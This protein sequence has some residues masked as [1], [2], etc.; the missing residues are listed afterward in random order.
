MTTLKPLL[1]DMTFT[2]DDGTTHRSL[3]I[4]SDHPQLYRLA[5]EAERDGDR[6]M[7]RAVSR[8]ATQ[9]VVIKMTVLPS[10][11]EPAE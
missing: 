4:A 9:N 1:F 6:E 7:I 11:S 10:H 3:S 8:A 2:K 5:Q